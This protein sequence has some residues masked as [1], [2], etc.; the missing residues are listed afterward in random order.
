MNFEFITEFLH[1]VVLCSLTHPQYSSF[2]PVKYSMERDWLIHS[3]PGDVCGMEPRWH[4]RRRRRGGPPKPPYCHHIGPEK[5][6]CPHIGTT[7]KTG[8][9]KTGDCTMKSQAR[10]WWW[11]INFGVPGKMKAKLWHDCQHFSRYIFQYW[12][13]GRKPGCGSWKATDKKI[14]QQDDM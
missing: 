13:S 6:R 3:G 7:R 8:V 4:R 14:Q 1:R 5:K 9:Q 11:W 2:N 10:K 12:V